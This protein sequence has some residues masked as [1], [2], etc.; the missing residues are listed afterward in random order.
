MT[1]HNALGA[2][3]ADVAV[4]L[5][6]NF[7]ATRI[8]RHAQIVNNIVVKITPVFWCVPARP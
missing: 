1:L 4:Q 6:K 3:E 2:R 7:D 5:L 8:L